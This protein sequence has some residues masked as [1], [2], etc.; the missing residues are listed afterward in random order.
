M[1]QL[2]AGRP[3]R[4]APVTPRAG[5]GKEQSTRIRITPLHERFRP[6]DRLV[7]LRLP[8]ADISNQRGKILVGKVPPRGHTRPRTPFYECVEQI[9][10]RDDRQEC[11]G[12]KRRTEV[13]RSVLPVTH[14]TVG[15]VENPA[16]RF[17][18]GLAVIDRDQFQRG[19]D[20]APRGLP[21][22]DKRQK[23]ADL[24]PVKLPPRGHRRIR[25]AMDNR[26]PQKGVRRD[27][28][29]SRRI[30]AIADAAFTARPM[31]RRAVGPI[32][33]RSNLHI[34]PRRGDAREIGRSRLPTPYIVHQKRDLI[35]AQPAFTPPTDHLRVGPAMGD[36]MA[37][38]VITGNAQCV[39]QIQRRHHHLDP[40]ALFDDDVPD[41]PRMPPRIGIR[42]P[43]TDAHRGAVSLRTVTGRTEHLVER[44][45][46][47]RSDLALLA[48]VR[49]MTGRRG[50]PV[51]AHHVAGQIAGVGVAQA[52]V[53]HRGVGRDLARKLEVFEQPLLDGVL[54]V[55][56]GKVKIVLRLVAHVSDIRPKHPTPATIRVATQA[57]EFDDVPLPPLNG[58]GARQ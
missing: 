21:R 3:L 8:G 32:Q 9:F 56:V 36:H 11:L 25:S 33:C 46:P 44:L 17:G 20:V 7:R 52:V 19:I 41:I 15:L 53:G 42:R 16:D 43:Q 31:T 28:Q 55:D 5:R 10:V 4:V 45:T 2:R 6:I 18:D 35:L 23:I 49:H 27:G 58:I 22:P 50:L 39:G 57:T 40:A 38:I 13:A 1:A 30:Q 48:R 37:Q 24:L 47:N 54:T 14:H 34:T 51:Q 26:V 29:K 12:V